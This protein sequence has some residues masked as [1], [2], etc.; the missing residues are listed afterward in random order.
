M[1]PGVTNAQPYEGD[2]T[3]GQMIMLDAMYGEPR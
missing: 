2:P 3:S 1:A